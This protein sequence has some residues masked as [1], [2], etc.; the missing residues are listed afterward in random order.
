MQFVAAIS[1]LNQESI[2]SAELDSANDLLHLYVADFQHLYGLRHLTLTFHQLLHLISVCKNLG[3]AWVFSCFTFESLNGQVAR[4]IHG[5][6]HVALQICSATA[7]YMKLPVLLN[8]MQD[9]E[10]KALCIR[11]QEKP[12][13]KVK[14]TEV[15]D[16]RAGVLGKFKLCYPVPPIIRRLLSDAFNIFGGRYSYFYRLKINGLVYSSE[17]YV[18]SKQKKSCFVEIYNDGILYICK[19]ISFIRWSAC[20]NNCNVPCVQCEKKYFCLVAVYDKDI[21]E[22]HNI[23]NMIPTHLSKVHDTG[24]KKMFPIQ[25]IRTMCI[26]MP[27][28]N[29]EY[30][31]VPINNLEVE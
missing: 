4:L 2:S 1:V 10:A 20:G 22:L 7:V 12:A 27:V 8:A 29:K 14:V 28:D 5:S 31:G 23:P 30:I 26:F 21:W 24:E 13:Q 25:A 15:I 17:E 16:E 11:F 9:S 3:P 18:R 19:V 6:R